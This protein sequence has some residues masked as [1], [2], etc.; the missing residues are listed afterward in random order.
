MWLQLTC[1]SVSASSLS[2]HMILCL[3]FLFG[4]LP[5]QHLEVP[6]LGVELELQLQAYTTATAILD[7]SHMCD[8]HHNNRSLTH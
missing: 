1:S 6:R 4:G 7:P 2:L 8:L 3:A 5:L